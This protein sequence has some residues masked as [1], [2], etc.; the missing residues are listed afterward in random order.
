MKLSKKEE[1]ERIGFALE[2]VDSYEKELYDNPSYQNGFPIVLSFQDA[3]HASLYLFSSQTNG[4]KAIYCGCYF[5]LI[6]LELTKEQIKDTSFLI[7]EVKA[8]EKK[9]KEKK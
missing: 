4:E 3:T 5:G 1:R 8:Q 2:C 9:N 6:H 7:N